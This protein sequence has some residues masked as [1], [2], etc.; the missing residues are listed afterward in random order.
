MF[1]IEP[2]PFLL[3][4]YRIS[5]F[6]TSDITANCLM[7]DSD[8][9]NDYLNNRFKGKQYWYTLNGRE[10]IGLALDEYDLAK[11]DVVTILTTSNNFYIS[12]CVTKEIEKRCSWSRDITKNTKV[13]FVNHE[14]GYPY[15]GIKELKKYNIPIIEDCASSFYS[16][17]SNKM[18]GTVGD[19]VIYSFP[20]MFSIQ[21]GGLLVSNIKHEL[22]IETQLDP[23][24]CTYIKNALA[25][26]VVVQ[27][28]IIKSRLNN[29]QRLKE[30]FEQ[31]GV[32]QFFSNKEGSVPGVFMF[33]TEGL[34]LDLTK[35]KDYYNQHGVQCSVF[36]GKEAFFLPVHQNLSDQDLLYFSEIFNSFIQ[37]TLR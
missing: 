34:E 27:D 30:E 6:K 15:E 12:G 20:K 26:Q 28:Q 33:S 22:E 16:I 37:N 36:Y 24:L 29:Y 9:F 7:A 19:F 5:P 21:I 8:G 1:I 2:D 4:T 13:I 11:D 18:I 10:A 35:L 14:F 23:K 3:P 25:N 32:S 17:D 31:Y